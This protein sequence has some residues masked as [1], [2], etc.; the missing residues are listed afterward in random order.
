MRDNRLGTAV[1]QH[2]GDLRGL[3]VPVD[4]YAIGTETLCGKARLEEGK[5]VAQHHSDRVTCANA[6]LAEPSRRTRCVLNQRFERYFP[7]AADH[8]AERN[9][10]HSGS[11]NLGDRFLDDFENLTGPLYP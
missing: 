2:I 7:R 4:R 8:S 9:L 6:D 11:P 1:V 10:L 3:A 5:V